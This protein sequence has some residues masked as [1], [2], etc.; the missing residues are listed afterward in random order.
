VKLVGGGPR[1]QVGLAP[2]RERAPHLSCGERCNGDHTPFL[3]LT[4]LEKLT[5][6]GVLRAPLLL[7]MLCLPKIWFESSL[8]VA[9]VP[10]LISPC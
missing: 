4:M 3:Q 2:F 9:V 10:I 7:L 5:T 6:I 1:Q 8:G